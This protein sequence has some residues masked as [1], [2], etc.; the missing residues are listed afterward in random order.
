MEIIANV[1][2]NPRTSANQVSDPYESETSRFNHQLYQDRSV[3]E[4]A[5][6]WI[7]GFKAL[8][9][10]FEFSVKNWIE[11]TFYRIPGHLPAKN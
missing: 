7:N 2:E 5:N 8:L 10:R 6:A 11:F 9:I 4:H 1:K 3:I